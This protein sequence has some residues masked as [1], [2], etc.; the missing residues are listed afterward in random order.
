MCRGI[1]EA[2][3]EFV[4]VSDTLNGS[5]W[6]SITFKEAINDV[7]IMEGLWSVPSIVE[8]LKIPDI[9]VDFKVLLREEAA[10]RADRLLSN[11]VERAQ[12]HD[13]VSILSCEVH[14]WCAGAKTRSDVFEG[15]IDESID[16][17]LCIHCS[18]THAIIQSVV[19]P[20]LAGYINVQSNDGYRKEPTASGII[21]LTFAGYNVSLAT[22]NPALCLSEK[23]LGDIQI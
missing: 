16:L 7:L 22:E 8:L 18:G 1:I 20:M 23:F 14:A 11:S 2:P 9:L 12:V 6:A 17:S 19:A 5:E 10:E 15:D 13:C 3:D 21:R 4:D